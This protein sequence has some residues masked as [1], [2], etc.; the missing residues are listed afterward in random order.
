M[1]FRGLLIFVLLCF[2]CTAYAE[3]CP[4][5]SPVNCSSLTPEACVRN[6]LCTYC[7]GGSEPDACEVVDSGCNLDQTLAPLIDTLSPVALTVFPILFIFFVLLSAFTIIYELPRF[8]SL[9]ITTLLGSTWFSQFAFSTTMWLSMTFCAALSSLE[10]DMATLLWVIQ[11]HQVLGQFSWFHQNK[12]IV[13]LIV[14][15]TQAILSLILVLMRIK[16]LGTPQMTWLPVFC[17]ESITLMVITILFLMSVIASTL[18][19]TLPCYNKIST[20]RKLPVIIFHSISIILAILAFVQAILTL[21]EC[22]SDTEGEMQA[23]LIIELEI[24]AVLVANWCTRNW[25]PIDTL[26]VPA[27]KTEPSAEEARLLSVNAS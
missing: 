4:Y 22:Q 23:R 7:S 5:I 19:D 6:F 3:V 25:S 21:G 15:S 10:T 18:F 12:A 1:S 17:L 16:N 13:S 20:H 14:V 27:S 26:M 8:F 2:C 9:V 11:L 24:S